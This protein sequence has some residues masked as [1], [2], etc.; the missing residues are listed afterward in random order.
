MPLSWPHALRSLRQR[1]LRLFFAGQAVSLAGTWMQSVAQAWLVWRLT[2]SWS[3]LLC[4]RWCSRTGGAL[5]VFEVR[6]TAV[7]GPGGAGD[8]PSPG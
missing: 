1:D 5:L 8:A 2:R 4:F 3:T 6:K 7:P